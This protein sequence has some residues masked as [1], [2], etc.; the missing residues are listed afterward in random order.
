MSNRGEN[1]KILLCL[2]LISIGFTALFAD[3]QWAKSFGGNSMERSW[4]IV[5]DSQNSVIF[6]GEF[7]D[8]LYVD[9]S[10]YLGLGLTDTYVIKLSDTGNVQW[11]QTL[12]SESENAGLGLGTDALDN[13]YVG[14]YFVGTLSCQDQSVTSNGMWD[15][16]VAK[17][18]SAGTLQW[19]KSFGGTANDIIHGLGVSPAGRVF[20]GGWFAMDID[21]GSGIQLHSQGGSDVMTVC[22][23]T[24]GNTL[25]ARSAGTIG[26]EYGY[27][28]A[29]DSANNAYTLGV[30]SHDTSFD[31][32]VL[33]GNG[34]FVAKYDANGMIQW[35]APSNTGTVI[36]VSVQPLAGDTQR[37]MVCGRL[38]GSGNIGSFQYTSIDG[39]DD[40]YW[41][42]FDANTGTW[43][44][45]ETYGGSSDDKG[46][47]CEIKDDF[48][49]AATFEGDTSFG[50]NAFSSLGDSDLVIK[51]GSN[52]YHAGGENLEIGHAICQLPNGKVAISGWHF[53]AMNLGD[54]SVDSGGSWNQNGFVALFDPTTSNE[55]EVS[56]VQGLNVYP[57]PFSEK[58]NIKWNSLDN[59][60]IDI[61]NLK[62]QKIRT[63]KG[64]S[65]PSWDGTDNLGQKCPQGI[66]LI[67]SGSLSA[68]ILKL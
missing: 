58:L 22:M 40:A 56:A 63:L 61:Y 66:Y 12:V 11:V 20:C 6:T 32:M 46:R 23:D 48:V 51:I 41:A 60:E 45:F 8:S 16:Y 17:F 62:G 43:I 57:N 7:V 21:F 55:D 65:E 42:T 26:V 18:N 24:D 9:G 15:S 2:I 64:T 49:I 5:S 1:M 59:H 27:K 28:I 67:N 10:S 52:Y 54:V 68:K 47:D 33:G 36:S 35:V 34:M 39:S 25:W 31:G 3:W 19:I 44:A 50:G 30:A 53:G 38:N 29:C 13:V 14:G 4:E 37:G